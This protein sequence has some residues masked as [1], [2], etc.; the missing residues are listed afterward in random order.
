MAYLAGVKKEDLR[1]LCEDIGLTV[2][3]KVSV[4]AIRDLIINVTNYDEEFTREHLKSIIQNRKS[5]YEQRMKEIESERA[6]ELEKLRLSQ[7]QQSATAHGL[8]VE[9]PTIEIQKLLL[10][11]KS[12]ED[13][14]GLFLTLFERHNYLFLKFLKKI[15][16][17]I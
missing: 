11:F 12:Q 14:I 17:P 9:K 3:S 15:L 16:L 13:D 4:I 8:G 10:K 7:P 1:S 6:F 5:D 2:T